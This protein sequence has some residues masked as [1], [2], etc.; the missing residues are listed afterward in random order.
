[1]SVYNESMHNILDTTRLYDFKG[2]YHLYQLGLDHA[3]VAN[4]YYF[5]ARYGIVFFFLSFI[6]L[7][8]K[9]R[10]PAFICTLMAMGLAVVVDFLVFAFWQRP[11]PFLTHANLVTDPM[12][13]GIYADMSTFPS[14]HTYMAFAV[15]ISVFLFGHK[16]LG[17]VLFI[18]AI[19]VAIGRIGS[20]LHYPS[21]VVAG[22]LLGLLSGII[23]Y[24]LSQEF[25]SPKDRK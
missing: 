3:W 12:I 14:S 9:K 23:V 11:R 4:F 15:A 7:I 17:T 20:G 8:W 5:F 19:C 10:I 24:Y 1:M 2:Y 13:N 6:Y 18:L 22:A 25:L 16:R 21:D